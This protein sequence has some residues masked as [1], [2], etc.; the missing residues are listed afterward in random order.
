MPNQYTSAPIE[1]RFWGQ[2]D[3]S[4]ECWVWTAS[5]S[6]RGYGKIAGRLFDRPY[7]HYRAHRVAYELTYGPIAD[8]LIVR[9]Y[10]CNN[11]PCCRPDHLRTGTQADNVGDRVRMGRTATGDR[12]GTRTHPETRPRGDDNWTRRFPERVLRGSQSG[13]AVLTETIVMEARIRVANGESQKALAVEMGFLYQTLNAAVTGVTWQHITNPPP[14]R[15][16]R[17]T[18]TR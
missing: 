9:H 16:N 12:H 6:P 1:Q 15:S 4:G 17:W 8:D 2:V 5:R 11:P 7:R 3:R 18:N 10:E 14:V 13:R